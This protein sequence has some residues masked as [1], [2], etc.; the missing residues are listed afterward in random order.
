LWADYICSQYDH[1][2]ITPVKNMP[3]S[4]KDILVHIGNNDAIIDRQFLDCLFQNSGTLAYLNDEVITVT[5]SL[6]NNLLKRQS[7]L[8]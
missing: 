5:T 8:L 3:L 4:G 7:F 2:I 1:Q 6:Y